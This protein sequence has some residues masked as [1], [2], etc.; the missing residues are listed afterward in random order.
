MRDNVQ[1]ALRQVILWLTFC[2]PQKRRVEIDRWQRGRE[3]Y[4]KL[5]EADIVLM[6]WGKSGRT[7]VRLMLSRFYQ[8]KFGL[9][10]KNFLEFDNLKQQE[11]RIPS[12]LF[13][14]GNYV[15]SYTNNLDS[16][17]DFYGKRLILL[18]RDPR[19]VA[20]S[21]FFQWKHRMRPWKKT[22]NNYPPHGADISL[23]NFVLNSQVGLSCIIDFLNGWPEELGCLADVLVV[24]YEDLRND[25][26][27]A[28]GRI[29]AFTNT[30]GTLE[31]IRGAVEYAAYDNMKML[32]KNRSMNATGKRLIPGD[33]SNPDSFKVRRAKVGGY[34]D[35]F[36]EQTLA[37]MDSMTEE[38]LSPSFGYTGQDPVGSAVQ[39]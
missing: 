34:R 29:V 37:K 33:Q 3:E 27:D 10:E 13:T 9:P 4:R 2:L 16:K 26:E 8:L 19:D 5:Q 14:H 24:R 18:V 11:R 21:Q 6:S 7:W 15:H 28:L 35:Y 30:P 32:E 36:D 1:S 12:V 25:P 22:I 20:L 31:D 38:R 39:A 17:V 23:P